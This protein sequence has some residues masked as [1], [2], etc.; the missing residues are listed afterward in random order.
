M[1]VRIEPDPDGATYRDRPLFVY[2]VER[3]GVEVAR[4]TRPQLAGV[5]LAQGR[6]TLARLETL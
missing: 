2:V 5:A 1:T 4:S 3:D 6:T